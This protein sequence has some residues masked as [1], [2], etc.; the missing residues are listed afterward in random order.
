M[1]SQ[2]W[3]IKCINHKWEEYWSIFYS[4]PGSFSYQASILPRAG[5]GRPKF[6]ISKDQL[7]YLSSLGIRWK[8]IAVHLE[9]SRMT[10]YRYVQ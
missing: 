4:N 6:L 3:S 5:L 10:V 1:Q 9:V 2:L 7:Q 8:E